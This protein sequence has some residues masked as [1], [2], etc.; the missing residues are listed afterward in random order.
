M[1]TACTKQAGNDYSVFSCII[2]LTFIS[3]VVAPLSFSSSFCAI[4]FIVSSSCGIITY[5]SALTRLRFFSISSA[6]TSFPL[7]QVSKVSEATP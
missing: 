7:R 2:D 3:L 4:Y 1:Q 5:S 6:C